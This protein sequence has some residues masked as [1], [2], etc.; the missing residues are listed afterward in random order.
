MAQSQVGHR[1]D[2]LGRLAIGS[3]SNSTPVGKPWPGQR[4]LTSRKIVK[5]TYIS[6]KLIVLAACS[7]A[8]MQ[9]AIFSL[10]VESVFQAEVKIAKS[11]RTGRPRKLCIVSKSSRSNLAKSFFLNLHYH[12]SLPL[13]RPMLA[14]NESL[15]PSFPLDSRSARSLG[16]RAAVSARGTTVIICQR[17]QITHPILF[18]MYC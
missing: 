4:A 17:T 5:V 8:N 12:C 11:G 2:F 16:L 9:R 6:V 13:P 18:P 3:T 7:Q 1:S 14:P 10:L 15:D